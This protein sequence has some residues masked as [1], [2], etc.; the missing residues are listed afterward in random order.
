MAVACQS[1]NYP[2]C[3]LL[4]GLIPDGY[5]PSHI[6]PFLLSRTHSILNNCSRTLKKAAGQ[7][8]IASMPALSDKPIHLKF[9]NF[10]LIVKVLRL[11]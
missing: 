5:F 9:I 1:I 8:L 3:K 4:S 6:R 11:R 7:K 10:A 2:F